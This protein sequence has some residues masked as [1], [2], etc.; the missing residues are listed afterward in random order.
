MK[1]N[2]HRV[3]TLL[4][5]TFAFFVV[6]DY[7]VQDVHHDAIYELSYKVSDKVDMQNN[8]HES[9]HNIFN[10]NLQEPSTAELK[11]LDSAPSSNS[12]SLSSNINPVPQRPPLS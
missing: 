4:L 10:C 7:V 5:L 2:K 6:H 1:K 9:I 3:L 12:F 8:I 11:L